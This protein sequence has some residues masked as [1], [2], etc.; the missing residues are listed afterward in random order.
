[1]VQII[2]LFDCCFRANKTG[3]LPNY[4]M[5]YDCDALVLMSMDHAA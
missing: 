1:M 5:N 2:L 3:N 4:P